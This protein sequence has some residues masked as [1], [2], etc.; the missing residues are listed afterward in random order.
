MNVSTDASNL[1]RINRWSSAIRMFNERPIF[2]WGPGTYMFYYAPF[3]RSYQK[4]IIST[5]FGTGGNAHSEYLGLLAD[6]GL[7]AMI[8]YILILVF[9]FYRGFSLSRKIEDKQSRVLLV[10]A[11]LGLVT[12]TLHGFMNDF[13]DSDK[14]AAPFWG[15]IAFVVALDIQYRKNSKGLEEFKP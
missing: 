11:L 12:Y 9:V 6:S 5:N 1:E 3:Q 7:I 2:G 8:G 4:T 14:I 15:F 13:L 10:G